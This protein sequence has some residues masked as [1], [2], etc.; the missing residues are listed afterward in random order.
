MVPS[1]LSVYLLHVAHKGDGDSLYS[2][3]DLVTLT[4]DLENQQG[5]A[6]IQDASAGEI[7]WRYVKTFVSYVWSSY[8]KNP[9]KQMKM[10][11]EIADL[12]EFAIT[13]TCHF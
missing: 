5:L 4:F 8:K 9:L 1:D 13:L 6:L 7:W 11:L 10:Q 12:P 2:D 3:S